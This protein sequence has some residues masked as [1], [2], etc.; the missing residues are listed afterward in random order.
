MSAAPKLAD[1][2]KIVK[3]DAAPS[4]A[5]DHEPATLVEFLDHDDLFT[6]EPAAN[7][8][9]A[10]LGIAPGPPVGIFG[11]SYVGK[12]IVAAAGGMAVALGRDFWGVYPTRAGNWHHFDHE[13]GR[14]RMKSIVQRLAV[15]FAANTEDLRGRIRV[16]IYP[17]LNLTTTDAI[18]HYARAFDGAAV[19]TLDALK[20][21][22]PGIDENSSVMRD[23]MG[24]LARASEKTG[25]VPILLHNVGKT[26]LD[27][28]RPR[29][30]SARGSSAIFD[31]CATAF[32][33]TTKKGEDIHVSHEKDR[34]LGNAVS[35]FG[36]RIVDVD[37]NGNPR[38]GLRVMYIDRDESKANGEAQS[39]PAFRALTSRVLEGLRKNRGIAG[40]DA[41]ALAIGMGAP[42]VR[43]A[44][45]QLEA[46]GQSVRRK[47]PNGRGARLYATI[48]APKEES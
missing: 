27:G 5:N 32:V 3:V 11:Q 23:Y 4:R 22:T 28:K 16:A 18:D 9:V 26:P 2:A 36:L 33:M 42:A 38:G 48:D 10:A 30:E 37:V 47:G 29:K 46:E 34:E 45:A 20:G 13:Q 40:S 43:A 35:D 25:C 31:E 24:V 12:S 21:L 1:R 41:L 8:L 19:A 14:R 44:I 39:G 17:P 6:P 7:L 15:G